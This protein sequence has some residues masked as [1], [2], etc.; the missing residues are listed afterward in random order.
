MR[1]EAE[2]VAR[3][4][5]ADRAIEHYALMWRGIEVRIVFQ[6]SVFGSVDCRYD[7]LEVMTDRPRQPLPISET[8]YKSL[9]LPA[10]S[11]EAD[12][13]PVTFVTHW[14]DHAAKSAQ[15]RALE[16]DLRQ[17]SLF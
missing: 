14:L 1:P 12:S 15:W 10:G 17:G 16:R 13:D 5:Q 7:H 4:A 11:I 2:P 3:P 9:F 8:G 6:G